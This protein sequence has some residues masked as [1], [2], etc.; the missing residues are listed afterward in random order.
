MSKLGSGRQPGQPSAGGATASRGHVVIAITVAILGFLLATQLRAQQDLPERL[1]IE[2]ESDLGQILAQL[3]T[4]NDLLEEEILNLRVRLADVSG[5]AEQRR[6]LLDEATARMN[7]LRVMLGIAAVKGPG[8]VMTVED[9]QGTV[10]PE[11]LLDAVQEL[12]DAGAEAIEVG[13]VRVVAATSFAG[14]PGEITVGSR[15]LTPPYV[16]RA[17]GA[18]ATLAEA[19]RIPGGF[20]DSLTAR[21]GASVR[22]LRSSSVSILSTSTTPAFTYAQP[23]A[24]R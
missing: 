11:V 13:M 8:I 9:P 12:R 15:S 10:G 19:M 16:V 21:A 14:N 3:T 7:A 24:R 18:S 1:K 5:S 17:V 2:R 20:Q 23:R 6:A 22:I 4:R